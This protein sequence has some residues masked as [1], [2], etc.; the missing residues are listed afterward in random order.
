MY[1]HVSGERY[2]A[3]CAG[4]LRL[5]SIMRAFPMSWIPP[6]AG[7]VLATA[8]TASPV[9]AVSLAPAPQPL[10]ALAMSGKHATAA[11]QSAVALWRDEESAADIRITANA[12]GILT[13]RIA[14]IRDSV[15]A[16]GQA[17]RDAN[18]PDAALR[19]R[20]IIGLPMLTGMRAAG[21]DHWDNG[22]IYDA[23]SGKTYKAS[24]RLKHPDTLLVRG[25]V[26]LGFVKFGRTAVWVRIAESET[27]R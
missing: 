3:L 6:L 13:G 11:Q 20:A 27:A 1:L 4:T 19:S 16:N 7:L 15:D 24:M 17:P 23:R 14:A 22:A 10:P 25:Y 26:Q 5:H 21:Q 12:A 2:A 18:N 8:S 9:R